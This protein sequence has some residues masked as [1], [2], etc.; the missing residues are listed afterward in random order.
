M[1]ECLRL[2]HPR[3]MSTADHHD[4]VFPLDTGLRAGRRSGAHRQGDLLLRV[5]TTRRWTVGVLALASVAL[6]AYATLLIIAVS[7]LVSLWNGWAGP[8]A[9]SIDAFALARSL[10]PVLLVGWCTGLASSAALAGREVLGPRIAGV[11]AGAVGAGAGALVMAATD[12]L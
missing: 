7:L 3:G 6:L 5:R 1:T 4:L 10:A 12:L 2:D 11:A 8:E 9:V